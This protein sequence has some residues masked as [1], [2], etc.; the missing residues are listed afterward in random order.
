MEAIEER[1]SGSGSSFATSRTAASLASMPRSS[2]VAAHRGCSRQQPAHRP[3]E[4]PPNPAG[5]RGEK[6]EVG[7]GRRRDREDGWCG[8]VW[9]RSWW[10]KVTSVGRKT[11]QVRCQIS[12]LW[13]TR[14]RGKLSLNKLRKNQHGE[15]AT[16]SSPFLSLTQEN[17]T[18][19]NC[20]LLLTFPKYISSTYFVSQEDCS[21]RYTLILIRR[22]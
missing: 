9:L 20:Y 10:L 15:F 3:R 13:G 4:S 12:H 22:K 6:D 17:S 5:R 21:T 19:R 1:S 14:T 8:V 16:C 18:R 2:M 7:D 11:E